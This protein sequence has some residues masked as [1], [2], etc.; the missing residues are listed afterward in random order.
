M[1]HKN[2]TSYKFDVKFQKALFDFMGDI[3]NIY[4]KLNLKLSS[5]EETKIEQFRIYKKINKNF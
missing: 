4:D 1:N 2:Q 3:E 5:R